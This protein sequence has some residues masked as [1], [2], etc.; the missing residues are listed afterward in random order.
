MIKCESDF[1]INPLTGVTQK[2]KKTI[3]KIHFIENSIQPI[4]ENKSNLPFIHLLESTSRSQTTWA[5]FM[6]PPSSSF[7][8]DD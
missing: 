1:P 8:K 4:N 2:C 7:F 3:R 6:M 5:S